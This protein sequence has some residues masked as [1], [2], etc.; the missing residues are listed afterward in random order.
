MDKNTKSHVGRP[1][2]PHKMESHIIRLPTDAGDAVRELARREASPFATVVRRLVME[3]L[4]QLKREQGAG[5]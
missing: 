2:A 4:D 1:P 5:Q 3:R